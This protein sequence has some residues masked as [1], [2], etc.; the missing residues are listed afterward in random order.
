MARLLFLFGVGFLVANGL[1]IA[2]QLRYWQRRRAALL[3]W[4][5]RRPPFFSLQIG[6]GLAIG[7]LFLFNLVVRP[8][9]AEQLF[10]EGMMLVYYGYVV[11]ASVRIK[12]G[13]Y[14]DGIWSAASFATARLAR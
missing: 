2:E 7:I 11:P 14:R 6:I 5:S 8:A 12:R 10:G 4:P 13:F 1:A 3:T 9:A